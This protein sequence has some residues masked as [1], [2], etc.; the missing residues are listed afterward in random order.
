LLK[1]NMYTNRIRSMIARNVLTSMSIRG[2]ARSEL[3]EAPTSTHIP[4][5]GAGMDGRDGAGRHEPRRCPGDRSPL[6]IAGQERSCGPAF[7]TPAV[8]GRPQRTWPTGLL[9]LD[10]AEGGVSHCFC[11]HQQAPRPVLCSSRAILVSLKKS[12]GLSGLLRTDPTTVHHVVPEFQTNFL[13][14]L[15]VKRRV[16]LTQRSPVSIHGWFCVGAG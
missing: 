2:G 10:A 13:S 12:G 8:P 3:S 7:P 16:D 4:S 5:P 15:L 11:A 1:R 6:T 14:H 9:Q